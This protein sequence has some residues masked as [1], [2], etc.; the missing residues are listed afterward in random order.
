MGASREQTTLSQS[1]AP[2]DKRQLGRTGKKGHFSGVKPRIDSRR[3]DY[4]PKGGDVKV[5]M[6]VV[7]KEKR[8]YS[9]LPPIIRPPPPPP[10]PKYTH[11][12]LKARKHQPRTPHE[13]ASPQQQLQHG[14]QHS[15][16]MSPGTG[17]EPMSP[18]RE[19]YVPSSSYVPLSIPVLQDLKQALGG[20]DAVRTVRTVASVSPEERGSLP[21][22]YR[23]RFG[24]SVEEDIFRSVDGLAREMLLLLTAGPEHGIARLLAAPIAAGNTH[25]I[26]MVLAA[27]PGAYLARA[28]D[29][30]YKDTGRDMDKDVLLAVPGDPGRIL[31]ALIRDC[32]GGSSDGADGV[33]RYADL[34][35][36][37][38]D[39]A[40]DS[41]RVVLDALLAPSSVPVWDRLQAIDAAL[42]GSSETSEGLLDVLDGS[43]SDDTLD[44]I[45][46]L[47]RTA[48]L[49]VSSCVDRAWSLVHGGGGDARDIL[50]ALFMLDITS[51][52]YSR[53]AYASVYKTE[54]LADVRASLRNDRN[55]DIFTALVDH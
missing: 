52:G 21:S 48:Q 20:S 45:R 10:K 1:L 28:R 34:A 2:N 32:D 26:A 39:G 40:A 6:G 43:V 14:G 30:Y 11:R 23:E 5:V 22:Q 54:L 31:H 37:A 53:R 47:L 3:E 41:I 4:V 17:E 12:A 18:G 46:T 24:V 33:Q 13:Q 55:L 27:A 29:A 19:E 8:Q 51:M 35:Q 25:A 44:L 38:R 15:A 50:C 7:K 42:Q 16:P 9:F 49:Q 36:T